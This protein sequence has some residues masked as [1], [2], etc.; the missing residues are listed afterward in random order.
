MHHVCCSILHLCRAHHGSDWGLAAVVVLP[1]FSLT[2]ISAGR[3]ACCCV[4]W[5]C[6][7][8]VCGQP[9]G[10]SWFGGASAYLPDVIAPGVIALG[11]LDCGLV[12]PACFA[13]LCL[14]PLLTLT[15]GW[16]LF[17]CSSGL[18]SPVCDCYCPW[19]QSSASLAWRVWLVQ[20]PVL[21]PSCFG[22]SRC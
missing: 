16:L 9:D 19:F 5:G 21:V 7:L 4:C 1:F 10:G 11:L 8:A 13:I 20:L 3:V 2:A 15:C 22:V 18:S 6:M 12:P 14:L 17:V